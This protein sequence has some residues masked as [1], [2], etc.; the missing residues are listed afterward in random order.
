[1][2]VLILCDHDNGQLS[3]QTL[4]TVTAA[5]QIGEDIDLLVAGDVSGE[6]V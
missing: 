3:N 1:M 2:S 5:R 4:N 6:V